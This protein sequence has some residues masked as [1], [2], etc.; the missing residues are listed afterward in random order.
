MLQATDSIN[1]DRSTYFSVLNFI[2]CLT[3]NYICDVIESFYHIEVLK[4]Y[5]GSIIF[6]YVSFVLSESPS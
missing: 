2:V 4:K 5:F 1:E 3:L 6:H